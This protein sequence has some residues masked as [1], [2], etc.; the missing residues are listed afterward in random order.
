MNE[1]IRNPKRTKDG[2]W[3]FNDS[4]IVTLCIWA[5]EASSSYEDNDLDNMAKEAESF[6]RQCDKILRDSGYFDK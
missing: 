1:N 5:Y 3:I 2:K 4:D 6:R